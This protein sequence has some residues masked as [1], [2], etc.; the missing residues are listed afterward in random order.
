M[1]RSGEP[2]RG[3]LSVWL[4]R[5]ALSVVFLV[6]LECALAFIFSPSRYLANFEMSGLGGRVAVQGF[7]IFIL[8]WIVPYPLAIYHPR[9]HILSFAYTVVSQ[10]IGTLAETILLL[11]L[12]AGHSLLH[13]T[14][15]RFVLVDGTG[16]LL[17]LGTLLSVWLTVVPSPIQGQNR[18]LRNP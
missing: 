5:L 18:Q 14:G 8:L 7:G 13:A 2:R 16:L 6:N 3:A 15:L 17:L 12:P 11:T 4:A 1:S 9:R 10:A